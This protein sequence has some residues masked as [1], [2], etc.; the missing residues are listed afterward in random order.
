MTEH[1]HAA[2]PA[3]QGHLPS[4]RE[5]QGPKPPS[6]D[7]LGEPT[8]IIVIVAVL[9]TTVGGVWLL[10]TV[11]TIWILALVMVVE[12]ASIAAMVAVI[13][14]Q[15]SDGPGRRIEDQPPSPAQAGD[16]PPALPTTVGSRSSSPR[17]RR[18][19]QVRTPRPRTPTT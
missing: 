7:E 9:L 18:G 3:V 5:R 10:A 19:S 15:L 6:A 12:I 16:S 2:Q 17:S 4:A 1:Q 11:T 8:L 14:W 13:G